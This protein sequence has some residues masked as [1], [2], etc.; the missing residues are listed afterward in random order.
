MPRCGRSDDSLGTG[1]TM[2]QAGAAPG[3]ATAGW[4]GWV[5]RAAAAGAVAVV[6]AVGLPA[7]ASAAPEIVDEQGY[8]LECSGAADG[9]TASVSLYPNSILHAPVTS[10]TIETS[11]GTEL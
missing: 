4:A 2:R 1:M 11:A 6:V 10:V 7:S 5:R 3:M 9:Y 8:A